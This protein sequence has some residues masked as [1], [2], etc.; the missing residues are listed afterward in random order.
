VAEVDSERRLREKKED[1]SRAGE[2]KRALG[3]LWLGG[4]VRVDEG[5]R[6]VREVGG[7]G[8]DSGS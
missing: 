4:W 6:L 2:E 1:M 5:M 7:R 8:I 3:R